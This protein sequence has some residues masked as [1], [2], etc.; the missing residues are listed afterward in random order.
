MNLNFVPLTYRTPAELCP[1]YLYIHTH[2]SP[3]SCIVILDSGESELN[4]VV[5]VVVYRRPSYLPPFP[6]TLI[7]P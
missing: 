3:S 1:T 4:V 5:V 2:R 7:I 6:A